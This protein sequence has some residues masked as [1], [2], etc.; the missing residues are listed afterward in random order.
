M[1]VM[2]LAADFAAGE[3]TWP[4]VGWIHEVVGVHVDVHAAGVDGVQQCGKPL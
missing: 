4:G 1:T 3:V 2:Q